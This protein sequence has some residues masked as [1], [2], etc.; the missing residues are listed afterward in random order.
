[1]N[2]RYI[3]NQFAKLAPILLMLLL[4]VSGCSNNYLGKGGFSGQHPDKLSQQAEQYINL[5]KTSKDLTKKNTLL[6]SA[7]ELLIEANNPFWAEKTL[8]DVHAAALNQSQYA[9][10]HILLAKINLIQKNIPE[11][12]ELLSSI[13]TYQNLDYDTL[14]KLYTTK[15][16]VF[17]Q[18]GDILEAVQGQINL[19]KFLTDQQEISD[20]H[21]KIWSNLQQLTPYALTGAT[22]G[23]FSNI[24][25]GWL[26][27]AIITKRYDADQAELSRAL[28]VWQQNFPNHPANTILNL[29]NKNMALL[30]QF[31]KNEHNLDLT[32]PLVLNKIALLLPI[33]GPHKKSA[34]AIK[35]GFLAAMYN[36]K[37]ETKKPKVIVFD[38]ND[39]SINSVYK[40]AIG[41]GADFIVGPLIKQ[42]LENLVKTTHL[43]VPVLALNT[44]PENRLYS[45][46]LFQF[47]LSPETEAAAIVDKAWENHHKNALL[48]VQNN[49]LGKRI[50]DII[51]KNWQAKGGRIINTVQ[52]N[53]KTDLTSTIKAALNI[54]SSEKRAQELTALGIK[55]NFE[56]RR[57]QDLDCIFLI[58]N[59]ANARQIKPL[60]NFYYAGKLPTYATSNIYTGA[61]TG[62]DR[63]LN[64]IQFCDIPWMLDSTIHNR[65]I[66]QSI[67][68]LWGVD[69]AQYSR[70]YA[71]GVDAYKISN[72]L[73]QLLAM[74]EI[75][76]SGM[77]GILNVDHNNVISRKL[78][79]GTFEN[80]AAVVLNQKN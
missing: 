14:K 21:K 38:T 75:G 69:F 34:L 68:N 22:Q 39:Q 1:M 58:T 10:L 70:L 36:K 20:N 9:F 23:N 24:M 3:K 40:Q 27:V 4:L 77:T 51:S 80:G 78:M 72:Q 42:D 41:A 15:I 6:L 18:S 16:D 11:A 53:N 63:D 35:N 47:G 64:H 59:V 55:F 66:Y 5:A 71:L 50:E 30:E 61:K 32:N 33:T 76:I 2:F 26:N 44:L 28:L 60:L 79:W 56:P 31:S 46:L 13:G 49:D 65:L 73:Q 19:E 45:S 25:Q 43:S 48:I 52:V 8:A 62:L 7:A 12:K 57:R 29:S 37:S 54:E 74:P 17:L 67:K